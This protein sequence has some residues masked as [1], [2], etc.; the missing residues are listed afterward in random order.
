L[1]NSR[2]RFLVGLGRGTGG[3]EVSG[4]CESIEEVVSDILKLEI[5]SI[6]GVKVSLVKRMSIK[7]SESCQEYSNDQN[8]LMTNTKTSNYF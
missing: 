3:F 4:S 2:L 8:I 7:N 1:V 5:R 6:Y